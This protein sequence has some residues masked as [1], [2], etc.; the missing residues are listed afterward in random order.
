MHDCAWAWPIGGVP[1]AAH[2][3]CRKLGAAERLG[4]DYEG[5]AVSL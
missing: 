5:G 2:A 3:R 1:I 4:G